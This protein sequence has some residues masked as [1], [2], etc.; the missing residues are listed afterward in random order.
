MAKRYSLKE[1]AEHKSNDSCWVIIHDKVY[2]VSKFLNEHPGGEEVLLEQAG[3]VA[4]E[5]FED[6]GHSTDAREMMAEYLIG[7]LTDE[8]KKFTKDSGPKPWEGGK[9][10]AE[11]N[12]WVSW[13]RT[14]VVVVI[15]ALAVGYYK[16]YAST[17]G[18][19]SS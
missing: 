14:V 15:V 3:Q 4:T 1:V 8:D 18:E 13:M 16:S 6:V 7:E 19:G 10:A 9:D 17:D 12:T 2:D 11:D 5:A